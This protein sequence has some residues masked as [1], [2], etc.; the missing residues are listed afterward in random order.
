MVKIY[1]LE[2]PRNGQIRYVGKTKQTLQM[3]YYSHVSF[4]KL[5]REKSHKNSWIL[6]LLKLGLKPIIKLVEEVNESEW[7]DTEMYWISQLKVWGYN[8]TNMTKGG[9][10]GNGGKGCL[11]YKHTEEAKRN[12][13]IKNSKPKSQ[14]WID[15][16]A[17]SMRKST[18]KPIVQITLSGEFIKRHESFYTACLEVNVLGKPTST[19]KIFMLVVMVKEKQLMVSFG[20]MKM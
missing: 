10:S 6:Q 3:R 15:N 13:S 11:G 4:Y 5:Q 12:I 7:Q 14:E 20:N 8:L 18:A 17:N 2:D 1:T 16:V 9:E 19:K